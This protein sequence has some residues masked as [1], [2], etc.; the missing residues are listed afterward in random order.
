M[1]QDQDLV[2]HPRDEGYTQLLDELKSHILAAQ[3][4]AAFA[5]NRELVLLYWQIGRAILER[6]ALHGW[7]SG[8]I[9]RLAR[10]LRQTLMVHTADRP[11]RLERA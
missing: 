9:P 8:V 7:G 6:Q 2:S 4:R 3:A 10:D 5:V 11:A 1:P